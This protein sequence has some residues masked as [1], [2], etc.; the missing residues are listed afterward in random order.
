MK[1]SDL[2]LYDHQKEIFN[3]VK[4][5][6]P[7]LV[8]Y[9][10]PTGTGKT[11]TPLGL[12]E[13]H[14]VI[15]VCAARHVGLALARSAISANKKIAFAFGCSSAE[16]IR[17]HYFAAKDYTVDRRSG[18]IRKVDNSNGVKVEIMICDIRS[19]LPAMYYMLAFNK[20][21]KIVVQWDEPTITMDYDNHLL[22]KIIKKNWSENLI[23][24][25]VLSSA[26]LPQ[27]GELQNI[28]NNYK[29]NYPDGKIN[30]I[31]SNKTLTGCIIKDFNNAVITPHSKCKNTN[32][33]KELIT[34]IKQFPLLGKF[35]TLPFL[36]NLNEFLK[37]RF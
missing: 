22:H 17:L 29:N 28:I 36:M 1:Y 24:N 26:T 12:S 31:V 18:S 2:T 33:L 16:D 37:T 25:M 9:I 23:P 14:R 15:F 21:E 35:Y 13:G 5:R 8:L 6:Q 3:A 7:K 11:L 4:A 20:A 10:A 32:E 30:E 34:K 27:I 19:Y